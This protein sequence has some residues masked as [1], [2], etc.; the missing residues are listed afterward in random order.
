MSL[1]VTPV[2]LAALV[3]LALPHGV[4][5]VPNVDDAAL[6]AVVVVLPLAVLSLLRLDPQPTATSATSA[7]IAPARAHLLPMQCS[8]SSAQLPAPPSECSD[9][10]VS[11]DLATLRT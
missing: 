2:S 8:L 3:P 7:N 5:S 4:G 11:V 6:A 10:A 1:A 9:S